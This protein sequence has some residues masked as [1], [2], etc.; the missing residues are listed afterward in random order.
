[1]LPGFIEGKGGLDAHPG[2]IDSRR[3][4]GIKVNAPERASLPTAC[5]TST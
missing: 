5:G 3:Y 1:M 4:A 2:V